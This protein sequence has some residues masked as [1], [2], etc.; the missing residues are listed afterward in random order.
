MCAKILRDAGHDVMVFEQSS[1]VGGT[2]QYTGAQSNATAPQTPYIQEQPL[3]AHGTSGLRTTGQDR[4]D[5]PE[6]RSAMSQMDHDARGGKHGRTRPILR[7]DHG[8]R[9]SLYASLRTNLPTRTL[10]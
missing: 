1:Q 2:W 7:P 5:E 10:P 9:S 8:F 6:L 4:G 3:H